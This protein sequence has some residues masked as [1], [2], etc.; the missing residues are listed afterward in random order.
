MKE[1]NIKIKGT[2][3]FKIVRKNGEVEEWSVDN[4]VVNGGLGLITARLGASAEAVANYLAV[5]TSS[6]AVAA[7]QTALVAEITDSGLGR[8]TGTI[9]QQTTT[10]TNDTYQITKTWTVSGTKT[11]EEAGVFNASSSGTMLSRV[12]T[13]SKTVYSGDTFTDTYKLVITRA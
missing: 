9:S 6:T 2:H 8:A 12:L 13:T 1:N 5:G 11:I 10:T 4:M 7:S 3:Y